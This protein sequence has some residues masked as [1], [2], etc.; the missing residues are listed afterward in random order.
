MPARQAPAVEML[1]WTI[2]RPFGFTENQFSFK[3]Y[4]SLYHSM[5]IDRAHAQS[6][7]PGASASGLAKAYFRLRV[8]VASARDA[9]LD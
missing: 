3:R 9:R 6:F 1:N 7:H 5:Q 2:T 4:F 8:Q